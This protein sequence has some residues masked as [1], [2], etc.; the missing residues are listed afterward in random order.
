VRIVDVQSETPI[1]RIR[2]HPT[3]PCWWK[4]LFQAD[5]SY[6]PS[7]ICLRL[8]LCKLVLDKVQWR[9]FLLTG[10]T[11]GSLRTGNFL[12]TADELL[13]IKDLYCSETNKRLE[14]PVAYASSA[15]HLLLRDIMHVQPLSCLIAITISNPP[16]NQHSPV[17]TLFGSSSVCM[18]LRN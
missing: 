7:E 17:A 1:G 13:C 12:S 18:T 9:G 8:G 5:Y 16:Y 14:E 2:R 4:N 10:T 6:S 15:S 11:F 3:R